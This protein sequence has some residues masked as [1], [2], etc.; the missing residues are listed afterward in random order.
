MKKTKRQIFALAL[1]LLMLLVQTGCAKEPTKDPNEVSTG[2]FAITDEAHP[3]RYGGVL[4][5]SYTEMGSTFDPYGQ[6]SWTT[7]VWAA[8]V[9]ESAIA[10]GSDGQLYPLVCNFEIS[11]DGKTIKL[12]VRDGVCFSDGTPVTVDDVYA[13]LERS[14]NMIAATKQYLWDILDHVDNDGT[15]LTFYMKEFNINTVNN[16]FAQCRPYCGI[17]PASICEKYGTDLITDPN[18]VIGT[19]PYMINADESEIGS[20]ITFVRNNNYT[21]CTESPE[22]NG[23]ASPK[24]QYLDGLVFYPIRESNTRLMALMGNTLDIIECN[25]EDT[26][27]TTLEPL[28]TYKMKVTQSNSCAYF[29]F[30]LTSSADRPVKDVNLR[31]AIAACFDYAE[32]IYASYGNLGTAWSGPMACGDAY[33]SSFEQTDYYGANDL[34]LAKQYL[35]ASDYNGEELKLLGNSY[36]S[37][38]VEAMREIGINAD[39]NTPDN[40]TMVSYANDPEQDWDIIYRTNPLAISS[41]AEIHST[42]YK[43]WGNEQATELVNKLSQ[44]MM[45]SEESINYWKQLDALMVE[46]VPC[47]V[48]SQTVMGY[49]MSADLELNNDS[50]YRMYWNA[51]WDNPSE[52]T[53]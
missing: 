8:N 13:S 41:P 20:K 35:A 18:D 46:E 37:I 50:W 22:N 42:M 33:T 23:V 14:G 36:L 28:G 45:N 51:Y 39:Y 40:T 24:Y 10:L 48:V 9:Y 29:F 32:L 12:W 49:A 44:S 34:A 43:T 15:T 21:V 27:T 53:S 6:S 5:Y 25:N 19:G 38:V 2:D 30:N 31:K 1:A 26:F 3:E 17:M 7:Y 4:R 47:F 11:E 16:V 52:H